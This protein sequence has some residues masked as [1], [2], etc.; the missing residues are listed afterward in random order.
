MSRRIVS[1]E[2]SSPYPSDQFVGDSRDPATDPS[3]LTDSSNEVVDVSGGAEPDTTTMRWLTPDGEISSD[4]ASQLY[5]SP[6]EV[7]SSEA[8]QI[9]ER[10]T[11]TT[12]VPRRYHD[13]IRRYFE[14]LGTDP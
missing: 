10:A 6:K 13:L 9:A 7:P 14:R 3:E 11:N 2:P 8:K 12:V 1:D 4:L 5:A